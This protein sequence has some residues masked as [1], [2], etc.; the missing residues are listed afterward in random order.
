MACRPGLVARETEGS[1]AQHFDP[2][3]SR[4]FDIPNL[5]KSGTDLEPVHEACRRGGNQLL[6]KQGF[7]PLAILG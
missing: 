7:D 4:Q 1:S 5:D 3:L 6:V 2:R